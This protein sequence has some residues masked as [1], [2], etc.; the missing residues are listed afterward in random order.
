MSRLRIRPLEPTDHR[1]SFDCGVPALDRYF[2]EIVSQD[3]RRRISHCFVALDDETR[4]V[5]YYTLAAA[6][7]PLVELPAGVARRLPRYDVLPAALIG[8]LAVDREF[9][10]EGLGG[11][12]I[13]D[14]IMRASRAEPAIFAM[15]VDAKDEAAAIYYE[16]LSFQRLASRPRSLFL[17][18]AT[19]A[20]AM[21]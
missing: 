1:A 21:R 6:S 11:A 12:L 14:A 19:A 7:I 10:G 16:R 5:G 3:V 17:S 4:V 15:L 20:Q 8:R 13:A 2:R 18:L 9:Q